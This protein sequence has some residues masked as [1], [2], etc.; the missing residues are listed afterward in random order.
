MIEARHRRWCELN[1][2]G[3][4]K[5]RERLIYGTWNLNG[6]YF[7]NQGFVM[8][9]GQNRVLANT[10]FDY[11]VKVNSCLSSGKHPGNSILR[12]FAVF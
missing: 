5:L 6:D 10:L 7:E 11:L 1:L 9:L 3:V 8:V 2:Y 12:I 4:Q